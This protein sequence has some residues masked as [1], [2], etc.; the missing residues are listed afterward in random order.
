MDIHFACA[1]CGKCCQNPRLPLTIDEGKSWLAA[2]HDL[3][4]L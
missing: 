4:L 2:G 1:Q 3:Q